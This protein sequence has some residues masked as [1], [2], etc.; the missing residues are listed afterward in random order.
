[1][2]FWCVDS[3]FWDWVLVGVLILDGFLALSFR[4]N[5]CMVFIRPNVWWVWLIRLSLCLSIVFCFW[6]LF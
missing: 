3:L 1:M 4:V 6:G 5:A 2:F